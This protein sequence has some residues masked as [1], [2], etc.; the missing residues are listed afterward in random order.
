MA[1][2]DFF[3][4]DPDAKTFTLRLLEPRPAE[5]VEYERARAELSRP[6]PV[7]EYPVCAKHG[8]SPTPPFPGAPRP[9]M[10]ECP[11]CKLESDHLERKAPEDGYATE[12]RPH[13]Q[14]PNRNVDPRLDR[15]WQAHLEQQR[16][17]GLAVS[18]S[19]EEQRAV[20]AAD[21]QRRK[22]IERDHPRRRVASER[23]EG[24][25]VVQYF[26][27][28]RKRKSRGGGGASWHEDESGA[29]TVE[30]AGHGRR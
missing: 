22:D 26:H 11:E 2:P 13:P 21:A 1:G 8:W 10:A 5:L 27:P 6:A 7:P 14:Y 25:R 18:G 23:I 28:P 30:A 9:P 29:I 17:N 12:E 16:E 20:E 3:V 19:L 15:A 4:P 24:G